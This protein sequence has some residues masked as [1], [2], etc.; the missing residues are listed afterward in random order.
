[1]KVKDKRRQKLKTWAFCYAII[2]IPFLNWAFWFIADNTAGIVM[3][4]QQYN[5][6]YTLYWAGLKNFKFI[7]DS[8]DGGVMWEGIK[9]SLYLYIGTTLIGLPLNMLFAFYICK[10]VKNVNFL[11]FCMM[12]PSMVSGL[13]MALLFTQLVGIEGPVNYVL[14]LLKL[15]S[16]AFL[17]SE[18]AYCSNEIVDA[19]KVDGCSD[20]QELWYIR[21]PLVYPTITTYVVSGVIGLFLTQGPLFAFFEYGA[22][23]SSWTLAYYMFT[24]VMTGDMQMKPITAALSLLLTIAVTPLTFLVRWAMEKYGPSED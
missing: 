16:I 3:A 6:D 15:E 14:K 20:M 24:Q 10:R 9:N 21:L 5:D 22:P 2:L 18:N 19:A 7:F 8:L 1:M 23:S 4:F 12:I 11:R 17:S 13:V